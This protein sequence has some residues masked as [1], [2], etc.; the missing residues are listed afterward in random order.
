MT[1]AT[2]NPPGDAGLPGQAEPARSR[3]DLAV[4]IAPC[5]LLV[6][7]WLLLIPPSGGYFPRSW[8]PA[9]VASVLG[10]FF[11]LFA[12]RARIAPS[13]PLQAAL[14]LFAAVV[15]WAFLSMTWAPSPGSAWEAANKLILVLAMA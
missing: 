7:L 5:A 11:G 8:Y 4:R 2:A 14:V 9:A 3:V 13:R 10:F 6:C 1:T 12:A 15:A